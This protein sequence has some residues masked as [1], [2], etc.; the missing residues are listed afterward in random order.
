MTANDSTTDDLSF[1]S[2]IV[3][4]LYDFDDFTP[5]RNVVY[6]DDGDVPGVQCFRPEAWNARWRNRQYKFWA[7]L[8]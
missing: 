6:D 8:S 1:F 5:V 7:T 4:K 2:N 3:F